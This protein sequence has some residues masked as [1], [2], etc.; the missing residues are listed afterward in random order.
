MS[1]NICIPIKSKI[2]S[3][4]KTYNYSCF[5]IG[6]LRKIAKQTNK[7]Y[8]T[9]IKPENYKETDKLKLLKKIYKSIEMQN[10]TVDKKQMINNDKI[11]KKIK[12]IKK[13]ELEGKTVWLSNFDIYNVMEQY[14]KLYDDFIFLGAVPIDFADFSNSLSNIKIN[15]LIKN[16]KRIG[17]VF[18]TDP[19]YEPGEHWISCFICFHSNTI[20]FFDSVGTRPPK[21]VINFFDK[22]I[23]QSKDIGI[24]LKK[25]INKRE[26]QKNNHSCGIYSLYF[27][28]KRLEGKGCNYIF[29][30]KE[31][32]DIGMAKFRSKVFKIKNN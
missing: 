9:K 12:N 3:S 8:G 2:S 27:I 21:E 31:T 30:N 15:K 29:E 17:I 13:H 11:T 24:N 7:K 19:S 10:M 16:K 14:M 5:S 20:C 4:N 18:N 32:S 26:I 22:I 25:I 1:D 28:I 23:K 6:D